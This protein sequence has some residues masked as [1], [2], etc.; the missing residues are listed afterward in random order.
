[1]EYSI[2]RKQ[3]RE[4]YIRILDKTYNGQHMWKLGESGRKIIKY[5]L[6]NEMGGK[7]VSLFGS[8]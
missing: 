1:V 6:I 8:E 7:E 5:I 4:I 3:Q 2:R